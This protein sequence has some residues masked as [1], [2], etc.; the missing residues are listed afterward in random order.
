MT[1]AFGTNRLGVSRAEELTKELNC[2]DYGKNQQGTEPEGDS[3]YRLSTQV[4]VSR[5]E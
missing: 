4:A 3:D 1:G 2:S 5:F